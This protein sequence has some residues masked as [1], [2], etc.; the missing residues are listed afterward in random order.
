MTLV[1][2]L[3]RMAGF[4]VSDAVTDCV[5]RVRN[6]MLTPVAWPAVNVAFAGSCACASELLNDVVPA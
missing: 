4:V 1:L 5:P 6:D 3:P 2:A